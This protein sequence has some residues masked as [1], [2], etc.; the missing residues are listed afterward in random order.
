[1]AGITNPAFSWITNKIG[2]PPL[3]FGGIALQEVDSFKHL[4]ITLQNDILWDKHIDNIWNRANKKLNI[5]FAL[6]YKLDRKTLEIMYFSF[7]RPL[8]EYGDFV[9]DNCSSTL[10]DTIEK[11]QIKAARIVSGAIIRTPY[12]L[13]L[14]DSDGK[15]FENVEKISG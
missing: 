4:G 12:I 8:L 2:H 11:V 6:K 13:M 7:I 10:S 1:M 5:L 9:W 14:E 3:V 15:H